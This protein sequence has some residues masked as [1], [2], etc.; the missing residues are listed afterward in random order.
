MQ[1]QYK[2]QISRICL[3]H[4]LLGVWKRLPLLHKHTVCILLP[5][6]P[7]AVSQLSEG[8]TSRS[9]CI[10]D[11]N[12]LFPRWQSSGHLLGSDIIV[13]DGLPCV[14][15]GVQLVVVMV[16]CWGWLPGEHECCSRGQ[17]KT[18]QKSPWTEGS[19]IQITTAD[20]SSCKRSWTCYAYEIESLS[21]FHQFTQNQGFHY[22]HG[23][24]RKNENALNTIPGSSTLWK[25]RAGS[26][27]GGKWLLYTSGRWW[28]SKGLWEATG[29]PPLTGD[30][31]GTLSLCVGVMVLFL[32]CEADF[33][34]P[35][36]PSGEREREAHVLSN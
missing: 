12:R 27:C 19:L 8:H 33:A 29:S 5:L 10:R 1:P 7:T 9:G 32:S 6:L 34:D 25:A 20:V 35:I 36:P 22:S 14:L 26:R 28:G 23:D 31:A 4:L 18:K 16:A 13:Q 17:N 24:G 11:S 15:Y 3:G 21:C 2:E 30:L